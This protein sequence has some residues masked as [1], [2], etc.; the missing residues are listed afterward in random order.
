[1]CETSSELLK[2]GEHALIGI[3]PFNG[4]FTYER[5]NFIVKWASVNFENFTIFYPDTLSKHTLYHKYTK[6]D[7]DKKVKH[8]DNNLI[9]SAISIISLLW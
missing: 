1:M 3:S 4:Y 9:K 6:K 7:L 2:K 8:A 5:I